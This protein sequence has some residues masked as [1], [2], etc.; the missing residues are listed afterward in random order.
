LK[1][2]GI[3]TP[4]EVNLIREELNQSGNIYTNLKKIFGILGVESD[5]S[6]ELST[7]KIVIPTDCEYKILNKFNHLLW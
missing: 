4:E 5:L 7:E 1:F 6:I 2:K 3:D